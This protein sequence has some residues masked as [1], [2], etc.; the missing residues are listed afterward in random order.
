MNIFNV[1][2]SPNI[3]SRFSPASLRRLYRGFKT[4]CPTG[5]MTEEAFRQVFAKFFPNGASCSAYSHY[6]FSS[7]DPGDSGLVSFEEFAKVLSLLKKGSMEEKL[8]W[9][10]Q[11]YDINGDGVLNRT[12]IEDVTMAVFI[13]IRTCLVIKSPPSSCFRSTA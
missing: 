5:L 10:F 1:K 6:V 4:E 12:E 9:T 13:L 8:A 11:L 2:K 3:S 7:M